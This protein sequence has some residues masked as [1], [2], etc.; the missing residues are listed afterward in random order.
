MLTIYEK[1]ITFICQNQ[2]KNAGLMFIFFLKIGLRNLMCSTLVR[3]TSQNLDDGDASLL[4]EDDIHL[5]PN[6]SQTVESLEA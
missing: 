6:Q 4:D 1:K 3:V 5:W 2:Y